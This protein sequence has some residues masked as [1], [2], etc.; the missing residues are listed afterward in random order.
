MDPESHRPSGYRR[1]LSEFA[2]FLRH[3]KK[4]WLT[5]ILILLALM[6]LIIVSS[7]SALAPLIYT[8][9]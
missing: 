3:E 4:W 2:H 1:I 6:G 9:I 8:L 5:P 7:N